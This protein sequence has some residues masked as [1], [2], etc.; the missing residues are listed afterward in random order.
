ME[1]LSMTKK[2]YD[3]K[4]TVDDG[5]RFLIANGY[6][7]YRGTLEEATDEDLCTYMEPSQEVLQEGASHK[8]QPRKYQVLKPQAH[9]GP[10]HF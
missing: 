8:L 5:N 3:P 4:S 2:G 1:T 9:Q 6:M 7:G 10:H